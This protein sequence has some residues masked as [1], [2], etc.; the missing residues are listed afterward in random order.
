[1]VGGPAFSRIRKIQA[2]VIVS[3]ILLAGCTRPEAPVDP[4]GTIEILG[5]VPGF[6]PEHPPDDWVVEGRVDGRLGIVSLD[7]VPALRIGAGAGP[8][9]L[10]RRTRAVLLASPYLSWA[11]NVEPQIRGLHPVVLIVGFRND[12]R[13]DGGRGRSHPVSLGTALPPHNRALVLAWGNSALQRGSMLPETALA[14]AGMGAAPRYVVRGGRE[15]GEIWWLDTVDLSALYARAW[16]EDDIGRVQVVFVAI[17]VTTNAQVGAHV[18]G[19]MLA[20]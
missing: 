5:P 18:A 14:F 12:L 6:S 1:M 13:N 9:L 17:A 10:A 19:I 2:A 8:L 7:G 3:V 20:R 4:N 15:N 16:P 11:W